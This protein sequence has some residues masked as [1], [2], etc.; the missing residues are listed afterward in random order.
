[1][2]F[3]VSNT[4]A[5]FSKRGYLFEVVELHS[6]S[7]N[8]TFFRVCRS[9]ISDP[10]DTIVVHDHITMEELVLFLAHSAEDGSFMK[11]ALAHDSVAPLTT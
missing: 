2:P 7:K 6:K 10:S 11:Y 8:Q 9:T 5:K 3:L 1:M 4:L